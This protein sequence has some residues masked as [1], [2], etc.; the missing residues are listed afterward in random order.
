MAIKSTTALSKAEIKNLYF[1]IKFDKPWALATSTEKVAIFII[2]WLEKIRISFCDVEKAYFDLFKN[3]FQLKFAYTPSEKVKDF[4][5]SS[6]DFRTLIDSYSVFKDKKLGSFDLFLNMKSFGSGLDTYILENSEDLAIREVIS[7]FESEQGFL[8]RDEFKRKCVDVIIEKISTI[9]AQQTNLKGEKAKLE[10]WSFKKLLGYS[11]REKIKSL[12]GQIEV[13]QKSIQSLEKLLTRFKFETQ[14]KLLNIH[15][16]TD[17]KV[18]LMQV[19]DG[20]NLLHL[21]DLSK[22]M[23][24]VFNFLVEKLIPPGATSYKIESRGEDRYFEIAYGSNGFK[25]SFPR[26][27]EQG[28]WFMTSIKFNVVPVIKGKLVLNQEGSVSIIFEEECYK[29]TFGWM[30]SVLNKVTF[31]FA[32]KPESGDKLDDFRVLIHIDNREEGFVWKKYRIYDSFQYIHW[33]ELH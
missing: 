26:I 17:F 1:K 10:Q 3:Q 13:C 6:G 7:S 25:G 15:L 30:K 29:G 19:M 31:I 21:K 2:Y 20:L 11:N 27:G 22:E 8:S 32:S 28:K 18:K 16:C 33:E 4:I 12:E 24:G 9:R 14:E 5:L 23:S